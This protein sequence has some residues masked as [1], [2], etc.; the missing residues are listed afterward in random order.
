M[1]LDVTCTCGAVFQAM[2]PKARYCSDRCRKRKRKTDD[3]ASVTQM[4]A[5]AG[6]I[7]AVEAA[8]STELESVGRLGSTLGQACVVLARRLDSPGLDTGS[9]MAAVASRLES[10]MA[11]ATRGAG[12]V[13]APQ[14]L[15]DELAS[16]RQKH[17]A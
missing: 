13:S 3:L 14:A 15:R 1:T 16:R 17:G 10:M 7:G 6:V 12:A 2:S 4:L 9:A 8:A 5:D 11:A